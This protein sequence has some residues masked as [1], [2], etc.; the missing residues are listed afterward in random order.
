MKYG[1]VLGRK[2]PPK[3]P[4][5]SPVMEEALER[6]W[7]TVFGQGQYVYGA[8]WT[9]LVRL[10]Q[11]EIVARAQRLGFEEWIFPRYIPRQA[12]DSFKLTQFAPNLLMPAGLGSFLDPVQCISFYHHLR[13]R[14]VSSEQL[15][16]SVVEVMGGWTWR[17]ET[18]DTMDGPYR[19]REFLRVEHVFCGTPQQ[20]RQRRRQVRDN[21][22]DLMTRLG[23]GGR[24]SWVTGAWT[25][26]R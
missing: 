8:K 21:L 26:P 13:D 4:L 17:D 18:E 6:K 20:V 5:A 11:V 15:P 22:T 10:L 25:S 2:A 14:T 19:A 1:T 16:L 23:L 3:P 7:I 9:R 24:L 12:L